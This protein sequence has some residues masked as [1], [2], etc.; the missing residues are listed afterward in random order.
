MHVWRGG[1]LCRDSCVQAAAPTTNQT[2]VDHL[3]VSDRITQQKVNFMMW[4]LL[5][6]LLALS[7][8]LGLFCRKVKLR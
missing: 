8:L 4:L 2:A 7:L 5:T 3:T 6:G 1:D